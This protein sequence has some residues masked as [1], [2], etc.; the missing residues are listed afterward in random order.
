[1]RARNELDALSANSEDTRIFKTPLG[2]PS[3]RCEWGEAWPEVQRSLWTQSK[4]LLALDFD[5]VAVSPSMRA[6]GASL[7]ADL[8]HLLQ[9]LHASRRVVLALLSGR[10]VRDLRSRASLE[11]A[12]YAGN[13]GSE[14]EGMGLSRTDG[15]ASSCRSDLVDVFSCLTRYSR[16]LPGI[17]ADDNGL[18]LTIHG[19]FAPEEE[20]DKTRALLVAL[21]QGRPRLQLIERPG[22]WDVL[23]RAAWDKSQAIRQMMDHLCITSSSMIFLAGAHTDKRTFL[24]LSAG[25]TFSVGGAA[26]SAKYQLSTRMDLMQFLLCVLCLVNDVSLT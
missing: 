14:I 5:G 4:I 7:P 26:E 13:H 19:T 3:S 17:V 16:R 6:D 23:A 25:H 21:V 20:R 8:G 2:G 10:S 24:D 12:I 9:K 1:M 11:K 15:L 22:G 18:S